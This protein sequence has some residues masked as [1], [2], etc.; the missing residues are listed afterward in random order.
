MEICFLDIKILLK[1]ISDIRHHSGEC[2]CFQIKPVICYSFFVHC[3]SNMIHRRYPAVDSVQAP[4]TAPGSSCLVLLRSRPDT[5]HRFP[6]RKTQTSTPLTGGSSAD[7]RPPRNITPAIADCRYKG[8]AN[9]PAARVLI[10][11]GFSPKCQRIRGKQIAE[12]P[13]R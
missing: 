6:S 8:T 12:K 9:T 2:F 5:V 3:A 13:E 11:H 7:C 10:V 4:L 1:M